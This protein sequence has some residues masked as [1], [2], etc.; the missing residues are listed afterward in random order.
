MRLFVFFVTG[1]CDADTQ[2]RCGV[3]E[4]RRLGSGRV[5]QVQGHYS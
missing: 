1:C 3:A 4:A 2:E 5:L